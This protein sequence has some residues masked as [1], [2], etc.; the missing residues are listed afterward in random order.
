MA[1]LSRRL[2]VPRELSSVIP[3]RERV[4]A[5]GLGPERSDGEPTV[6]AATIA[7]FYAPGYVDPLPWSDIL[8]ATWDDPIL[9]IAYRQTDVRKPALLR[10]TLDA[11][12]SLPLAVRDRVEDTIVV[13]HHVALVGSAGARLIARRVPN[14]DD[15]SWVIVFDSS[16]DPDDPQLR[17]EADA[18]LTEFRSN[19]GI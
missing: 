12:G 10:I 6:V 18:A 19:L 3:K 9:E 11:P 14:S 8:R 1:F 5:W 2:R 4:L 16:L 7:A 13:Q 15:I 17:A